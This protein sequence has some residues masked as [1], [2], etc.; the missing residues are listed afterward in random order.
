MKR[1]PTPRDQFFWARV[2]EGEPDACWEW[3]GIRNDAGYGVLSVRCG[4]RYK[5]IRAHRVSYEL[6]Y[7]PLDPEQVI[8]H[9]CDNP[10]CVN[11]QHLQPGTQQENLADM[12]KK[13]R[14]RFRAPLGEAN[15][16]A[17][18]NAELVRTMR[19]LHQSGVGISQ[20][21]RQFK[22][23]ASTIACA[24]RGITW[25]HVAMNTDS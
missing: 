4:E 21:A 2:T 12:V 1:R 25:K 10:A 8:M 20:L 15:G 11:P 6:H 7:G 22:F 14:H 5:Q 3:Q 23:T 17:K 13:G 9:R 18:L 24:V 19:Q 16:N